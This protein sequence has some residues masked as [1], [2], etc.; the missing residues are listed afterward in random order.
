MLLL[1][2]TVLLAAGLGAVALDTAVSSAPPTAAV[3]VE[4]DAV[5]NRIRL[6]HRGGDALDVRD[7]T[8][9]VRVDGTPL[10]AQ[11]PV[12][13]FAA[14]GFRAGPTGPFNPAADPWWQ[15]GETTSVRLAHTNEPLVS[16]G[17]RVVVE[18]YY[19]GTLIADAEATA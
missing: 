4:A 8:V 17:E 6:T 10:A 7:L 3:S 11:P 13:F 5:T 16:T 14:T 1:V 12:P 9:R 19:G 15:V 18:L 2:A